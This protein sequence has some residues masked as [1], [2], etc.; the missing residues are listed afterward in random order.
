MEEARTPEG[1]SPAATVAAAVLFAEDTPVQEASLVEGVAAT[2]PETGSQPGG[3]V[4]SNGGGA[5]AGST[6][7]AAGS[8]S[9]G[10]QDQPVG[11][12]A[13]NIPNVVEYHLKVKPPSPPQQQQVRQQR[14]IGDSAAATTT[15]T[16]DAAPVSIIYI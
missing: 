8:S 9:A 10:A 7:G 2:S 14:Q 1:A 6:A 12:E 13:P 5:A 4:G 15:T 11:H 16:T 3:G